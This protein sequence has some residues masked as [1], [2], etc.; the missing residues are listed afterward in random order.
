MERAV[1]CAALSRLVAGRAEIALLA[2]GP[3]QEG[4]GR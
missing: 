2:V 1:T 4:D 3:A